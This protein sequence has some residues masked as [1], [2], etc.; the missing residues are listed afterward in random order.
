M[1]RY[2]ILGLIALFATLGAGCAVE[3]APAAETPAPQSTAEPAVAPTSPAGLLSQ[4]P[5]GYTEVVRWDVA[6]LFAG[7]TARQLQDDFRDQWEW[8]E[9]HGINLEDVTELVHAGDGQGNTLVL[10]AGKFDWDLL[11]NYL[12]QAGFVDSSYRN[13]EVWKHPQRDQVVGFLVARDQVVLSTSGSAGVRDTIRA[14]GNDSGFLFEDTNPDTMMA[15]A[16]VMDGIHVIWEEGCAG[17]D[18]AGCGAVAYGAQ[19]GKDR[20]TMELTWLF[21]FQKESAARS[22]VKK[23]ESYFDENMP[24]EVNVVEVRQEGAYLLVKAGIDKDQFAFSTIATQVVVRPEPKVMPRPT[25]T[26]TPMPVWIPPVPVSTTLNP[27]QV[28]PPDGLVSWWPGDGNPN[29]IV[30]SN[31]GALRGGVAFV[32]GLVGQAFLLDGKDGVVEVADSDTLNITGDLTVDLWAKRSTFGG[33]AQLIAKGSADEDV[34]SVF[35]LSFNK[36]RAM[37]MFERADATNVLLF[38]PTITDTDFHH[39]A[40]VRSGDTHK[41]FIDG[42]LIK[43]EEFTGIAGDTSGIPL[44]IGAIRDSSQPS[45]FNEFFGGMIDEVAIYDRALDDAEIKRIYEAGAAGQV[46]PISEY[47]RQWNLALEFRVTPYQEN[48]NRDRCGNL[49]VWHFLEGGLAQFLER[50]PSGYSLLPNF[51][52]FTRFIPGLEHWQGS[53]HTAGGVDNW[54]DIGINNTGETQYIQG[55]VW[56][57]GV[58]LIQPLQDKYAIVG[59]QSPIRGTVAVSGGVQDLHDSCGNG[60]SW[61]IDHFDGSANQTLA[62]GSIIN[63][64]SQSFQDGIGAYRLASVQVDPG[65]FLYFLVDPTLGNNSCDSTGLNIYITPVG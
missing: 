27:L 33:R 2:L 64:G 6:G 7:E 16:E 41:M 48:P 51:A 9:E 26:P 37:W 15:M 14:L 23:I 18:L 65:D 62:F 43:S 39:Y 50:D 46:K 34:P 4:V 52:F 58:V 28:E 3:S 63:G 8:I 25:P 1:N 61:S 42:A 45:G 17:L 40:Y 38:G 53:V 49:D 19:W 55:T 24:R 56:P 44:T 5:D 12:Y 57:S 13:I 29:D 60:I 35:S 36:D 59:W 32:P 21:V 10:L 54:S 11:H 31:H 30:A 22:A 20:F 47:C